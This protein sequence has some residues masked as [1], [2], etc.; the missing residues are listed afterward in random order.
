MR[1]MP[2]LSKY[3]P[4]FSMKCVNSGLGFLNLFR[5]GGSVFFM[6]NSERWF[7]PRSV[8]SVKT[9]MSKMDETVTKI[10]RTKKSDS[11]LRFF[12]RRNR[13]RSKQAESRSKH[14]QHQPCPPKRHRG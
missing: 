5:W 4:M 13:L 8:I 3:L 1:G 14:F 12:L 2:K 11:E 7:Y 9:K 10:M 6:A